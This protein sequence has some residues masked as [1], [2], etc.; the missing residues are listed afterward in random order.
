MMGPGP[1]CPPA[2]FCDGIS[3]LWRP[4]APRNPTTVPGSDRGI[5][6]GHAL[7]RT[8]GPFA[9]GQDGAPPCRSARRTNTC[10]VCLQTTSARAGRSLDW[11]RGARIGD[12]E[13]ATRTTAG[14]PACGDRGPVLRPQV[15]ADTTADRRGHGRIDYAAADSGAYDHGLRRCRSNSA[16]ARRQHDGTDSGTGCVA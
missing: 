11:A 14:C 2:L 16:S 1:S 8:H 12:S 7:S 5:R 3:W 13:L 15:A 9:V 6:S 10:P 4:P